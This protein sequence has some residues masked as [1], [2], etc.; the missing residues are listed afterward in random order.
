MVRQVEQALLDSGR[1]AR[2][3]K[4]VIVAG[5]PPGSPGRINALRMHQIGDAIEVLEYKEPT[6]PYGLRGTAG[7]R[8]TSSGPAGDE[9]VHAAIG[10][11]PARTPIKPEHITETP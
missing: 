1:C 6:A 11:D 3:A 9:A 8:A 2:G 7:S 5:N 4:I 10:V